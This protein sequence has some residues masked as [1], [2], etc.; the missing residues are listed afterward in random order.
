[1][2][3]LTALRQSLRQLSTSYRGGENSSRLVRD[4]RLQRNKRRSPSDRHA[5]P[6]P[7]SKT[8]AEPLR[9][10][11]S[12]PTRQVETVILKREDT[13]PVR[14]LGP[15]GLLNVVSSLAF[16]GV[17]AHASWKDMQSENQDTTAPVANGPS[18][19]P[20]IVEAVPADNS[21]GDSAPATAG[22]TKS[23]SPP[24]SPLTPIFRGLSVAVAFA[25]AVAV[26]WGASSFCRKRLVELRIVNGGNL[27]RLY[28]RA[29]LP[30][31][32]LGGVS[33]AQEVPTQSL[34]V[35]FDRLRT[36][37]RFRSRYIAEGAQSFKSDSKQGST[38]KP[39]PKAPLIHFATTEKPDDIYDVDVRQLSV[40]D[41]KA[42]EAICTDLAKFERGEGN[43]ASPSIV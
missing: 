7:N 42:I 37:A 38:Q 29:I 23:S 11:A 9:G 1:M 28:R 10:V 20:T 32:K 12:K 8:E 13:F 25:T 34:V 27:V 14:N 31:R 6:N 30:S 17:V 36:A 5:T 2:A 35:D 33:L 39:D 26:G 15:L 41:V 4:L 19:D 40:F 18:D 21:P 16:C 3:C 43:Q 22:L 24:D